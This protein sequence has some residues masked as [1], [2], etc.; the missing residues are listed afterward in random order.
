MAVLPEGQQM[1]IA[2]LGEIRR[3]TIV[4]KGVGEEVFKKGH[5]RPK[6][7]YIVFDTIEEAEFVMASAELHHNPLAARIAAVELSKKHG[8]VM[9]QNP[10]HSVE[11]DD[12]EEGEEEEEEEEGEEEED[13]EEDDDD[14]YE[15]ADDD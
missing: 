10:A 4:E 15:R 6:D 2:Y 7:P 14:G 1:W 12:G 3:V 5:K 9:T 13:V 8:V 11:D